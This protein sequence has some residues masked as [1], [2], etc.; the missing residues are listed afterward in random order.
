MVCVSFRIDVA[1]LE[2][3]HHLRESIPLARL[4]QLARLGPLARLG[5]LAQPGQL[6]RLGRCTYVAKENGGALAL[7]WLGPA[8][9]WWLDP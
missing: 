3:S 2:P 5:Q 1:R 6:A 8:R 4:G 7:T 9:L